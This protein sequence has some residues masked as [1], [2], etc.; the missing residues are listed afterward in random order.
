[1][2]PTLFNEAALALY[3]SGWVAL[4]DDLGVNYRTLRRWVAGTHAI[5]DNIARDLL[6]LLQKR[7]GEFIEIENKLLAG[8]RE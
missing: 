4:A 6:A 3:P 1:M 8:M 5:P 7:R 2:T